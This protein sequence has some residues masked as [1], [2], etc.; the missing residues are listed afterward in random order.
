MKLVVKITAKDGFTV[1]KEWNGSFEDFK[2]NHTFL[3]E[4]NGYTLELL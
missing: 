1:E 2:N 4:D 3:T